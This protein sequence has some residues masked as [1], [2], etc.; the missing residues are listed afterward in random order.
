M[1]G[2]VLMSEADSVFKSWE[3]LGSADYLK[4]E[5]AKLNMMEEFSKS[6]IRQES[7]RK[8]R[9]FLVR[10]YSLLLERS[11]EYSAGLLTHFKK[12]NYK[13]NYS[14]SLSKNTLSKSLKI[15]EENLRMG[16]E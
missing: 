10:L 1:R 4:G 2:F 5:L 15:I 14:I 3:I 7:I 12:S 6:L 9:E 13:S 11:D 8:I 16:K